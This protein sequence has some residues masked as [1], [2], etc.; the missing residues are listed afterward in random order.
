[1][2]TSG[3]M[4]ISRK[5]SLNRKNN[6]ALCHLLTLKLYSN[7]DNLKLR[8]ELL[9]PNSFA[10]VTEFRLFHEAC[11]RSIPGEKIIQALLFN[12]PIAFV[13]EKPIRHPR[14]PIK[15]TNQFFLNTI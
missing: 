6:I 1:M 15:P 3:K 14:S 5:L 8:S 13:K 7:I 9:W 4:S 12:E 11:W 10:E 2:R